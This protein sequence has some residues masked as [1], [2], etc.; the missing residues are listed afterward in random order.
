[1]CRV[2]RDYFQQ[3]FAE[4]SGNYNTVLDCVEHRVLD[5]DNVTL[6]SPFTMEEFTTA[7]AQMHL[8]KSPG[9]DGLNSAFFP[10]ILAGDWQGYFFCLC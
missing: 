7:I 9:P 1:M 4:E 2:A 8:D 6:L 3:L 5:S 10:K